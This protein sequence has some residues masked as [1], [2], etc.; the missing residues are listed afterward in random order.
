MGLMGGSLG[1]ALK[2][3]G[4]A[5]VHVYAR[6][7]E[8]R[9]LALTMGAADAA[10][11]TPAGALRGADITVFCLPV[12]SIPDVAKE[13]FLHFEPECVVTD[14]GSTKV[15]LVE[16]MHHLFKGSRA[17][18][19]GSHPIA[20]SEKH[21]ME[22]ATADLY[23]GTMTAVT[24]DPDTPHHALEVVTW[25][26]SGVG[27]RVVRLA[28]DQHDRLVARTSHLPH[29]VASLLA[30]TVGRDLDSYIKSFCGTGFRDSS[31]VA[32]GSPDIWQ[33]VVKT[34]HG[35]ILAELK[36]YGARLTD[37]IHLVEAEDYQGV[38]RFLENAKRSR[39]D[40]I[41]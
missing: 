13:C 24:P 14:V 27:A 17:V 11:E 22:A 8:T 19:V 10:F 30:T 9:Q 20:G 7:E 1:L 40:L 41:G 15:R 6:R 29:L 3:R 4:L 21:G 34:N 12:C 36:A 28:P 32:S 16:A 18:F 33:D 35:A 39:S 23:Q 25:L 26:W 2:R 31:R 5:E 37:L 38:H